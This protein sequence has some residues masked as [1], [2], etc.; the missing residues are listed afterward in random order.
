MKKHIAVLILLFSL[1]MPF[2]AWGQNVFVSV[3]ETQLRPKPDFLSVGS[4]LKYGDMLSIIE[5]GSSWINVRTIFGK[6]GYI[7]RSA[8]SERQIVLNSQSSFHTSGASQNDVVLAGK[9]FS[10]EVEEQFAAQNR[11]LNFREVDAMERPR[12]AP[13]DLA[14]FTKQG[15]LN[16]GGKL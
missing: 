6:Q 5:N 15:Q 10:R 1:S 2:T 4:V 13:A 14:T 7:H 9:G 8:I 12:V 16:D 11:T 3:R